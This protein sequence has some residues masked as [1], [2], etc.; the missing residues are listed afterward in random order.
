[1]PYAKFW[2]ALAVAGFSAA[3]AANGHLTATVEVNVVL[4]LLSALAVYAAPN[5]TGAP[6]WL[7]GAYTKVVL[8]AA[9]AAATML[10]TYLASAG[11]L[12]AIT[13]Q[14]WTQ[15]AFALLGALGVG[16]WPNVGA[17]RARRV[18]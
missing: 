11:S 7:G 18:T 12:H 14:E 6:G 16:V 10:A 1:M 8:A 3:A 2:V 4:A 9:T 13:P 15:I 17:P 5:V